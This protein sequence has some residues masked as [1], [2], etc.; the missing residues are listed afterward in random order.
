M[1]TKD[2]IIKA[3]RSKANLYHPDKNTDSRMQR[4]NLMR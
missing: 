1:A 2:E 3:Y 4:S